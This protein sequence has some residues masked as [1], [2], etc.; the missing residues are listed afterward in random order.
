MAAQEVPAPSHHAG[1]QSADRRAK[2]T[3]Q[4]RLSR[5][6]Q[7]SRG[8]AGRRPENVLPDSRAHFGI[9]E[10]VEPAVVEEVDEAKAKAGREKERKVA[11]LARGENRDYAIKRS[12]HLL[13]LAVRRCA[14]V[15]GTTLL[16]AIR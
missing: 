11:G 5:P 9:A 13:R 8:A 3:K 6:R 14:A 16:T 10:F 2:G 7:R 12:G 1:P 4:E 15:W